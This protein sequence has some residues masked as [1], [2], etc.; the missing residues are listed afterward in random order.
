MKYFLIAAL[1]GGIGLA[2]VALQSGGVFSRPRGGGNLTHADKP[3]SQY[4]FPKDLTP[5][6]QA[7]AVSGAHEYKPGPGPHKF[8]I[9]TPSGNLHDWHDRVRDEWQARTV[10]ETEIVLVVGKSVKKHVQHIS[11]GSAPPIDRYRFDLEVSVVD[12]KAGKLLANVTFRNNPRQT[13]P[14]ENWDTTQLG[15]PVNPGQVLNWLYQ[16]LQEGFP[17]EVERRVISHTTDT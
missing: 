14:T 9:M 12:V 6:A 8:V 1:V 11:Y 5:A 2:A 13:R 3:K 7:Y 16:R 4:K 15:H 17:D 10:E